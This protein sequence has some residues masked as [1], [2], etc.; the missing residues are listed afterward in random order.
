M[1]HFSAPS[2]RGAR[3]VARMGLLLAL[4]VVLNAAEGALPA[5]PAMPPGVRL[6]LSNIVVLYGVLYLGG[7]EALTIGVLKSGFVFLTRGASAGFIS[8]CGGLLSVGVMLLTARTDKLSVLMKSVLGALAHNLGQ[9]LA[10]ALYMKTLTVFYYAPVLLLAGIVMGSLTA[11][12][13]RAALP[14]LGRIS[15][16]R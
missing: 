13:T 9:L 11:V 2:R 5:L 12:L 14:A 8:L 4:A 16:K 10:A 7:R 15:F 6:G 1:A 3:W